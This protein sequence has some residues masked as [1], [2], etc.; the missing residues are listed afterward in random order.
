MKKTR[1]NSKNSKMKNSII[2]GAMIISILALSAC[3][4]RYTNFSYQIRGCIESDNDS[5]VVDS[6]SISINRV[7]NLSQI[8][9]EKQENII[10]MYY[11][12]SDSCRLYEIKIMNL[13]KGTYVL[14]TYDIKYEDV[15]V[16]ELTN[17]T[18]VTIR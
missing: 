15:S 3:T 11:R 6:S 16:F 4:V 1:F 9:F 12:Q 2:L 5:L 10:K 14:E 17:T 7:V 8:R 18:N 13:T